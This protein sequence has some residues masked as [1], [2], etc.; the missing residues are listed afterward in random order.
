MGQDALH[1][2][3]RPYILNPPHH[4]SLGKNTL[5]DCKASIRFLAYIESNPE[6]GKQSL[7]CT[8]MKRRTSVL[9]MDST[10]QGGEGGLAHRLGKR[11]MRMNRS[12]NLL[13]SR[14]HRDRQACLGD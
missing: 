13:C 8:Y 7:I 5:I 4:L 10:A 6:K 3:S 9:Y 14:L 1:L 2:A 11:R 12:G